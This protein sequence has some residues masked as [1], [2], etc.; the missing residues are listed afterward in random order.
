MPSRDPEPLQRAAEAQARVGHGR[1]EAPLERGAEVAMLL[2]EAPLPCR[3]I[4]LLE[5]RLRFLVER[6][7]IAEMSPPHRLASGCSA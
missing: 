5:P 3:L 4:G 6:S 7:E 1:G 2:F